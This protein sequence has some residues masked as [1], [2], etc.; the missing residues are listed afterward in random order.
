VFGMQVFGA[1]GR[2]FPFLTKYPDLGN[3][4]GNLV[5]TLAT[6]SGEQPMLQA[7][8]GFDMDEPD[9]AASSGRLG[10]GGVSEATWA[11]MVGTTQRTVVAAGGWRTMI[12][13]I[14]MVGLAMI[15]P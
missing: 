10:H 11:A 6:M 13:T 12:G 2:T 1:D 15:C 7:L 3:E 9:P 4:C 14:W 8:N 5:R